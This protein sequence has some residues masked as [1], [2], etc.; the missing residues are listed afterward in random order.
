MIARRSVAT[1][2]VVVLDLKEFPGRVLSSGANCLGLNTFA[3]NNDRLVFVAP[4][5]HVEEC[6][7]DLGGKHQLV[8]CGRKDQVGSAGNSENNSAVLAHFIQWSIENRGRA[9]LATNRHDARLPNQN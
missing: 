2:V 1:E 3:S 5:G 9:I 8:R 4:D 7:D 6:G